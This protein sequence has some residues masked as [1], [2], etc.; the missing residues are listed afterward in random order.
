MTDL[1][2]APIFDMMRD[3]HG[4][5]RR[6]R[7]AARWIAP[8]L[9]L[10]T[11]EAARADSLCA[12]K[13]ESG[14]LIYTNTPTNGGVCAG[15]AK[16]PPLPPASSRTIARYDSMVRS[17]SQHYGVSS[18]LVHA[19]ISTESAYNPGA[20]SNKGARGLM[21]LMPATAKRYGVKDSFNVDE[22]IRGG[23]AHLRDLLDHFGGDTRLAVAAYNAGAGAV[24]KYSGVP[25]FRETRDYVSRV[26]GKTYGG[27]SI[28]R[29]ASLVRNT[30]SVELRVGPNGAISLEN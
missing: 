19:V 3:T 9:A 28:T 24:H 25:P 15:S 27:P 18:S 30:G 4:R 16:A 26:L 7:R 1:A 10:L 5:A 29:T 12:F 8:A 2:P 22:N 13:S 17:W 6:I 11:F 23:V 21:Q 14:A 20:I